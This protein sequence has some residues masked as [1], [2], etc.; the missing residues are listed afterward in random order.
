MHFGDQI[1]I[2]PDGL[3]IV[4]KELEPIGLY[5]GSTAFATWFSDVRAREPDFREI[6]RPDHLIVTPF[7]LSS[8]PFLV[9]LELK[10]SD[11]IGAL[12]DVTSILRR[13][14]LNILSIDGIPTGHHHA[15]INIVGEALPVKDKR[16]KLFAETVDLWITPQRRFLNNDVWDYCC[17][18]LAP[19]MIG[20]SEHLIRALRR[21]DE[22]QVKHRSSSFLRGQIVNDCRDSRGQLYDPIQLPL[23]LRASGERQQSRTVTCNW[24]QSLAYFWVYR[25]RDRNHF[26]FTFNKAWKKLV[27]AENSRSNFHSGLTAFH[28]PFQAIAT[29]NSY[30]QYLRVV[31]ANSDCDNYTATAVIPFSAEFGPNFSTTK[32]FQYH[33]LLYLKSIRFNVRKISLKTQEMSHKNES[34]EMELLL[35]RA[36]GRKIDDSDISSLRDGLLR[37]VSSFSP[38]MV[39]VRGSIKVNRVLVKRL[40]M[41]TS[42]DW[43]WAASRKTYSAQYYDIKGVANEHGFVLIDALNIADSGGTTSSTVTQRSIALIKSCD[44]F[45]Q[46]IPLAAEDNLQWLTFEFGAASALGMPMALCVECLSSGRRDDERTISSWEMALKIPKGKLL[47][48]FESRRDKAALRKAVAAALTDIEGQMY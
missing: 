19:A 9:R 17:K 31:I 25:D 7:E 29:I 33:I 4:D 48:A 35:S 39:S 47:H 2:T 22:H 46:V 11:H 10:L 27:I 20:Y 34:S 23:H 5:D 3:R 16:K 1:A 32:G 41:S 21:A 42:L 6:P 45:L 15:T 14:G 12:S 8:W 38:G 37:S 43:I 40:F 26:T 44:A 28:L 36:D 18:Q 13:L 24:L 30:E